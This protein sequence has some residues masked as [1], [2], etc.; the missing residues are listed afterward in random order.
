MSEFGKQFNDWLTERSERE[1]WI[2]LA[3]AAV[4]IFLMVLIFIANPMQQGIQ[5]ARTRNQDLSS[6]LLRTES[7]A[8]ELRSL[9][10]DLEQVEA[11]IKPG[12]KTNLLT[13]LEKL[14]GDASIKDQLESVKPK[15]ASG[16][17]LYPETRVEVSIKGATRKQAVQFLHQ[18]ETAP[19]LLI[20]R[21]LR[22]KTRDDAAL[23]VSFSVSTFERG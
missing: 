4:A 19:V 11:R 23:D 22:I 10:A 13:L 3:A 21:S 12:E 1:R 15:Q 6:Q 5:E 16:N 18:I 9:R 7:T 14:A 8:N 17:A 20:V 2:I